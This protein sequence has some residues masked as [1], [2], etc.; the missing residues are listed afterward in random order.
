[1]LTQTMVNYFEYMVDGNKDGEP[2]A[3]GAGFANKL[4]LQNTDTTGC[5]KFSS[6]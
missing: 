3:A 1:M 6:T 4:V 2:D 5:R